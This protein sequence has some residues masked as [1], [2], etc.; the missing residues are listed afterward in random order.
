[1]TAINTHID[2]SIDIHRHN[3]RADDD[4]EVTVGGGPIQR[5]K[6]ADLVQYL[7][8]R[9]T[10]SEVRQRVTDATGISLAAE[11]DRD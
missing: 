8:D 7:R 4:A 9:T 2:L 6:P 5:V 11:V 10:A 3:G 1:M